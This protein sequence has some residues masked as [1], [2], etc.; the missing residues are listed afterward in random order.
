MA[1]SWIRKKLHEARYFRRGMDEN[2]NDPTSFDHELSAF[3]TA[4]RSVLQ[5][6]AV[7]CNGTGQQ[8]WYE[9]K[10][11]NDILRFFRCRRNENIHRRP[12][13]SQRNITLEIE[14]AITVGEGLL[15]GRTDEHGNVVQHE[16][17]GNP[18][19]EL[20]PVPTN[21]ERTFE[22]RFTNWSDE[23]DVQTLCDKYLEALQSTLEEWEQGQ[24]NG[25]GVTQ[26]A[27]AG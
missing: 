22:Y 21:V 2:A 14:E 25:G 5:Y 16:G 4:A 23:K 27:R 24:V 26:P 17:I 18:A 11:A 20:E 7:E 10:M 12:I 1:Q 13:E 8:A 6:L 3:L 19:T 9:R 15:I